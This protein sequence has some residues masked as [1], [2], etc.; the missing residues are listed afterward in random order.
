MAGGKRS[1]FNGAPPA[2]GVVKK[3]CG[4]V[5]DWHCAGW[6]RAGD[7]EKNMGSKLADR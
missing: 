5:K 3:E 1:I 7:Q 2:S 4:V 6:A